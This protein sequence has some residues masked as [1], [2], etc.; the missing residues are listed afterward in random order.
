MKKTVS[1]I[2]SIVTLIALM[3]LLI[4]CT[5]QT[6]TGKYTCENDSSSY[7]EVQSVNTSNNT[8]V[9]S[10]VNFSAPSYDVY[11]ATQNNFT[12]ELTNRSGNSYTFKGTVA[13]KQIFG[14]L[15]AKNYVIVVDGIRYKL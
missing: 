3:A 1:I 9:I 5:P 7:I 4:A 12:V 10:V 6:I 11:K 13:G 14:T 15:D 2:C 8:G